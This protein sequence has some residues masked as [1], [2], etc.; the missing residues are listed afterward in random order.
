[1]C[2]VLVTVVENKE[3]VREYGGYCQQ[4]GPRKAALIKVAPE[5]RPEAD[6]GGKLWM[7]FCQSR[8]SGGG[9]EQRMQKPV[10]ESAC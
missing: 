6:V 10:V 4:S 1:M 5:Q 9:R 2:Q 7:D 3:A 8:P